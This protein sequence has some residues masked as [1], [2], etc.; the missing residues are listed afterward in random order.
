MK[1]N[2]PD[3]LLSKW[4]NIDNALTNDLFYTCVAAVLL[5]DNDEN[6]NF[7]FF[8]IKLPFKGNEM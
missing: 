2:A 3:N 7:L 5:V 4:Q 8:L 1:L 6:T